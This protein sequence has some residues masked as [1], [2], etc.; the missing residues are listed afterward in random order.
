VL[1]GRCHEIS[2]DFGSSPL[3]MEWKDAELKVRSLTKADLGC[4]RRKRTDL[5]VQRVTSSSLRSK[6]L[7]ALGFHI[8]G[9]PVIAAHHRKDRSDAYHE[10]AHPICIYLYL[11]ICHGNACPA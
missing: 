11:R 9:K 4:V 8:R 5:F 6:G 1:K 10:E 2:F 7:E 3:D